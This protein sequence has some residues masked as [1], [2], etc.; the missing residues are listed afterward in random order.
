[1]SFAAFSEAAGARFEERQY[2]RQAID[3]IRQG[4][5]SEAKKLRSRLTNYPLFPY[6]EYY[7]LVY[8][9]SQQTPQD[10]E[11]FATQYADTPLVDPL[12][13]S[14]L[15]SLARRG[16][17]ETFAH[18]YEPDIAT[19]ALI[20]RYAQSLYQTEKID[21]AHRV[22]KELWLKGSSQPDECDEPFKRLRDSS[23]FENLAWERVLLAMAVPNTSLASYLNR[24]LSDKDRQLATV[25][26][27]IHRRPHLVAGH[28][29][30]KV[31]DDRTR[32]IIGHGIRRLARQN[33]KD[34]LAALD[35]YG[36]YSFVNSERTAMQRQ[37]A[38]Q[39]ISQR[40]PDNTIPQL[41]FNLADDA[42]LQA[43]MVRLSLFRLDWDGVLAGIDALP[44]DVQETP[45]WQFWRSRALSL[46]SSPIEQTEESRQKAHQL[47]V[48]LAVQRDFYG[49]RAADL[50]SA[51]Y[52][53]ADRPGDISPDQLLSLEATPGIQRA[54][55]LLALGEMS[56]AR[57]EWRNV[58]AQ[59]SNPE[60]EIAARVAAK[61]GWHHQAIRSAVDARSWDSLGIRYPVAFEDDFLS[62]ARRWDIP[63]TLS[64]SVARQE[65]MFMSDARSPAGALGVMQ[66]MPA[67]A[68]LTARR[69]GVSHK[70]HNQLLDADH[71]IKL[72]SAYLGMMLR[73]FDNN[74]VIASAAYN[75]GPGRADRWVKHKLP[76]DVW[77]ETIPFPE[78]R[79]YVQRVLMGAAI[80]SRHIGE[81]QPLIHERE[82]TFFTDGRPSQLANHEPK[83]NATTL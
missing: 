70:S 73:R 11:A 3:A 45:R 50:L 21:D 25:L 65:S 78:T 48:Q 66:V 10:I 12:K 39:L 6:V 59:F 24:F 49:F 19:T 43:R 15:D 37:I 68:R 35:H 40:D 41:T 71:N 77:I 51:D 64:L 30:L 31:D 28:Q 62:N 26:R 23:D 53:F 63:V 52:N 14:W 47:L 72:G 13:R 36:H 22:A 67:T 44:G 60:K 82:L 75:A 46:S 20:C 79:N 4:R 80:Y 32:A 57:R 76:V 33:G 34:A 38:S 54:F 27:Q 17:W 18:H 55:E 56:H 83:T 9:I 2:Y 58:T 42:D 69:F 8:S 7:Q 1:M 5:K 74:R 16:R 29:K 61:W 81:Q